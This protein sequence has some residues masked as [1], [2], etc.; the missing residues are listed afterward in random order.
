MDFL[1]KAGEFYMED[2]ILSNVKLEADSAN[3]CRR[4]LTFMSGGL[5]ET[6]ILFK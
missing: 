4:V 3:R 6:A 5:S 2:R 1:E